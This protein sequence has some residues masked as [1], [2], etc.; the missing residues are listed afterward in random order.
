MRQSTGQASQVT[1]PASLPDAVVSAAS[2]MTP[3]HSAPRGG[4]GENCRAHAIRRCR[5]AADAHAAGVIDAAQD[6]RCRRDEG[7][8]ADTLGAE[9]TKGLGILDDEDLDRRHVADRG[10]EIVV[11]VL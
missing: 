3:S 4:G 8:L 5:Y 10:G 11:Q 6:G 9:G 7:G 1:M 2:V